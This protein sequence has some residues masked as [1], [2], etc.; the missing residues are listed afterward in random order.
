M[1]RKSVVVGGTFVAVVVAV[2]VVACRTF[3]V[4]VAFPL[5]E[6]LVDWPYL[7]GHREPS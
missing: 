7:L 6:E 5:E 2:V 3:V 1:V 4:V